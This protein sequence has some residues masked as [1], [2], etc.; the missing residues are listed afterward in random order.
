MLIPAHAALS[1][2]NNWSCAC[3]WYGET[4]VTSLL[5]LWA[6]IVSGRSSVLFT[7]HVGISTPHGLT[8][9]VTTCCHCSLRSLWCADDC[10]F[11]LHCISA[12]TVPGDIRALLAFP[13][14]S[15]AATPP[16]RIVLGFAA[17]RS[18][19]PGVS[20]LVIAYPTV[21]HGIIAC[22]SLDLEMAGPGCGDASH[23]HYTRC[24]ATTAHPPPATASPRCHTCPTML[25]THLPRHARR[26]AHRTPPPHHLHH[27][28]RLHALPLP[29]HTAHNC[30][31]SL[32]CG[33]IAHRLR[34]FC[35]I[36]PPHLCLAPAHTTYLTVFP[37]YRGDA[38]RAFV[39]TDVFV[40]WSGHWTV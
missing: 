15:P 11:P 28:A 16:L 33:D 12:T 29:C 9:L 7:A 26:T 25:P 18:M 36:T 17:T 32:R 19:P 40:C 1:A 2:L 37:T 6:F 38:Q 13:E 22:L 39:R 35:C 21:T 5:N 4:P 24:T 23:A 30:G 27:L 34:A 31:A 14:H 3:Y 20:S 8:L 10:R